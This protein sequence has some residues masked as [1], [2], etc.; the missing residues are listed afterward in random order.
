[1]SQTKGT[2]PQWH[3]QQSRHFSES[4]KQDKVKEIECKLTTVNQ[5]S[6]QHG[7]SRTAVYKWLDKYS[8]NNG[9]KAR[10]IVE[11]MSDSSKIDALQARIREL[12]RIIG[13]KQIELEFKDKMIDLA[14]EQYQVDIKKKLGSKLSDGLSPDKTNTVGQ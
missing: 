9:R 7:V 5:V 3:R 4:F 11:P 1:M 14:E 13:Q 10:L 2:R 6:R 12:E 8:V